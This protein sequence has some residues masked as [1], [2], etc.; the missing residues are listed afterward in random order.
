MQKKQESYWERFD[1]LVASF[2]PALVASDGTPRAVIAASESRLGRKLPAGLVELYARCGNRAD[3]LRA[4]ERLLAPDALRM[5]DGV[6]VFVEENQGACQ[7]GLRILGGDPAVE[8]KD[9]T[10]DPVWEPDHARLS[11]FLVSFTLWQAV[12]GGAPAGGVTT[13]D[14]RILDQLSVW[15][16]LSIAGSHWTDV[17]FFTLENRLLCLIGSDEITVLAAARDE[18]RFTVMQAELSIDWDYTWPE[19]DG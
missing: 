12:N 18:S 6:L 14:R 15:R 19:N 11:D 1:A 3:L 7:W 5:D 2:F 4:H 17:R 8:R 16:E 9:F 10:V 13:T